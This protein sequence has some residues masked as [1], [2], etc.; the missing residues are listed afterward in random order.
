VR[1]FIGQF[2][3]LSGTAKQKAIGEEVGASRT[4]LAESFRDGRVGSLLE[5]MRLRSNSVKPRDLGVIGHDHLRLLFIACE[6]IPDTFEYRVAALEDEGLPY[7]IE[8]AFG[9]TNEDLGSRIF[10]GFNFTPAIVGSPFRLDRRL[11]ELRVRE[12]DPIMVAVHVV[13]PRLVF[14]DKGKTQLDLPHPVREKID[15]LLTAVT[16]RWTKQRKAEERDRSARVRRMDVLTRRSRPMNIIDAAYSVMEEAYE[17]ASAG[18]TLPANAR[19]V[20]YAARPKILA[21]TGK[22]T[23]SDAYFTQTILPNYVHE[24][25]RLGWNVVFDDR[26]HFIEPHTDC[27]IG[28][29]TTHVREYL[30]DLV[31]PQVVEARIASGYVRTHGPAGRYGAV[32]FIEKEPLMRV[33]RIAERFDIGIMSTKGLSVTAARLLID[34]LSELGVRLFVLHDF[35]ISGFSIRGTVATS[36]RRYQFSNEVEMV[37]LGLR[38]ADVERLDLQ[39]EPVAIE[40]DR[41]TLRKRLRINGAT[42]D[43]IEFPPRRPARRTE[44][45]DVR[46]LHSLH[47]GRPAGARRDQGH[48]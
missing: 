3:G 35:D 33:S 18:G 43:E 38:L 10:E 28:L 40:N 24:H 23:F 6:I 31:E 47:R 36:G 11:E 42:G 9:Y 25:N 4:T 19:Q 7:V 8:A 26:G 21:L 39:S 48:A 46:C 13:S 22:E 5:S 2:R 17:K 30:A 1:E 27:E 16:S 37:D 20:M 45:H 32:L 34:R 29:G 14:V 15:S 41:D 12:G 44:R